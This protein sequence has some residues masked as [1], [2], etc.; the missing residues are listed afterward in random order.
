MSRKKKSY[1]NAPISEAIFDVVFPQPQN[2]SFDLMEEFY[3]VVKKDFPNKEELSFGEATFNFVKGE[4]NISTKQ[5]RIGLRLISADQ[6]LHIKARNTGFSFHQVGNYRNWKDFYDCANQ[7]LSVYIKKLR[8]SEFSRVALRYVN[9]INIPSTRIKIKDYFHFYPHVFSES[10]KE[11][12]NV[13]NFMTQTHM[14]L[15]DN[16]YAIINQGLVDPAIPQH[17][18][19]IL[20]LDVFYLSSVNFSSPQ[21]K[22]IISALRK[23]KNNLFEESITDSTRILFE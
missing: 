15:E 6:L 13:I 2:F 3:S 20:D 5:Q 1:K 17:T 8:V 19:I 18:S 23:H 14:R 16:T 11:K 10:S 21:Y 9:K 22:K 7:S 4:A 12:I